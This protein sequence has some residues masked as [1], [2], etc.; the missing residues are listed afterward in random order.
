[1][2]RRQHKGENL[3]LFRSHTNVL[4]QM[5]PVQSL[6]GKNF[7]LLLNVLYIRIF[8]RYMFYPC[9]VGLICFFVCCSCITCSNDGGMFIGADDSDD[10]NPMSSVSIII[11]NGC[12]AFSGH[13]DDGLALEVLS[14]TFFPALVCERRSPKVTNGSASNDGAAAS[15]ALELSPTTIVVVAET[16]VYMLTSNFLRLVS[17]IDVVCTSLILC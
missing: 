2:I 7:P 9:V 5:N 15:V 1:V 10:G 16:I 12:A 6:R 3:S 4:V 17:T 11:G 8:F 14:N 13:D